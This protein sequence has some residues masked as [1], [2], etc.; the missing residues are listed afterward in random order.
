MT[1]PRPRSRGSLD[2]LERRLARE[3][4]LAQRQRDK[5]LRAAQRREAERRF[6]QVKRRRTLR[7]L[8][9]VSVLILTAV[10]VT[11]VMFRVLSL[12]FA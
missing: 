2:E 5:T 4:E 6:D 8:A 3:T 11:L 7:Y 10:L 12:V 1:S 9:L